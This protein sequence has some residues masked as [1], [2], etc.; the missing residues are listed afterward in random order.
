M[1]KKKK[2]M[3]NLI[4]NYISLQ[5]L[6]IYDVFMTKLNKTIDW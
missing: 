5:Y 3:N 4:I 1:Q 2:K 6:Y